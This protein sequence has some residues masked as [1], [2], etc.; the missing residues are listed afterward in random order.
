VEARKESEPGERRRSQT[1]N[2]ADSQ[3]TDDNLRRNSGREEWNLEFGD[4]RLNRQVKYSCIHAKQT[5]AGNK[6][7]RLSLVNEGANTSLHWAARLIVYSKSTPRS[8]LR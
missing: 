4:R 3:H 5:G 2:D 7:A 8:L 6:V 1:P